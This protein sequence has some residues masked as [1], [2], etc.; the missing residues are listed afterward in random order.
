[1][2]SA[3]LHPLFQQISVE[4][5]NTYNLFFAC[6]SNEN[7][8][9][10]SKGCS[11]KK[12]TSLAQKAYD[13]VLK[14]NPNQSKYKISELQW[15]LDRLSEIKQRLASAIP[16]KE[17]YYENHW[18]G[19]ITKYF[20]KCFCLWRGGSTG[21]I[22]EA[23]NFL[24]KADSRFYERAFLFSPVLASYWVRENLDLTGFFNYNTPKERYDK[25]LHA[26]MRYN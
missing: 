24:I 18:F 2:T 10:Y 22:I 20:L 26:G 1:M 8:Q 11:L 5:K 25:G 4:D 14:T 6:T 9:N 17:E 15:Q 21:A 12:L 23:E 3:I 16:Y 19:T 7:I 13:V